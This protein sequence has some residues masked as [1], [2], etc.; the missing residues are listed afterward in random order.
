M[1]YQVKK[2]TR[3]IVLLVC[4]VYLGLKENLVSL[5]FLDSRVFVVPRVPTASLAMLVAKEIEENEDH[6]EL[7]EHLVWM[8]CQGSKEKPVFLVHPDLK[9]SR[10]I[11]DSLA[12]LERM[13]A[14]VTMAQLVLVAYPDSMEPMET[15][16]IADSQAKQDCLDHKEPREKLAFLV[17]QEFR[18]LKVILVWMVSL[19]DQVKK[20]I[21]V[22]LDRLELLELMVL[23]EAK[24]KSIFRFKFLIFFLK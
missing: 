19:E 3:E 8:V 9:E 11:K 12:Y 20:E 17:S 18:D 4:L 1:G 6:Q 13:A 23:K 2:V 21:A 14:K 24:V 10:E 22:S 15:K 16:E 5:D 7:L